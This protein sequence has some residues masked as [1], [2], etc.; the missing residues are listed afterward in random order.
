MIRRPGGREEGT[1]S[2]SDPQQGLFA[3]ELETKW[4]LLLFIQQSLRL[5]RALNFSLAL[6]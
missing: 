4:H 1:E 6:V 3:Y 2:N 5:K